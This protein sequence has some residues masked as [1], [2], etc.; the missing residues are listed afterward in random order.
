MLLVVANLSPVFSIVTIKDSLTYLPLKSVRYEA[1]IYPHL[2]LIEFGVSDSNGTIPSENYSRWLIVSAEGYETQ[3]LL[4]ENNQTIYLHP[5]EECF[6][7]VDVDCGISCKAP[8]VITENCACLCDSTCPRPTIQTEACE[9]VFPIIFGP[10]HLPTSELYS[11]YMMITRVA[12]Y[13]SAGL[14]LIIKPDGCRI[15]VEDMQGREIKTTPCNSFDAGA[16]SCAF[17]IDDNFYADDTYVVNIN[18][19][20]A[21]KYF[22]ITITD[23]SNSML[24]NRMVM[25][26]SMSKTIGAVILALFALY[27]IIRGLRQ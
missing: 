3:L 26:V 1:Y 17:A 12:S 8:R 24:F 6:G 23:A 13:S 15:Y 7:E 9:C 22:N 18:C 27:L 4:V 10:L 21:K 2:D 16:I 11:E 14:Q 19:G 5:K 20:N 25:W